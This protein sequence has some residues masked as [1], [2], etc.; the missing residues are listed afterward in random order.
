MY[1]FLLVVVTALPSWSKP[2]TVLSVM[3]IGPLSRYK[4]VILSN[5]SFVTAY[6]MAAPANFLDDLL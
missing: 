6:C 5:D 1:P 4:E 2:L 3:E